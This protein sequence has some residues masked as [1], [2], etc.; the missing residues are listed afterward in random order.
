MVIEQLGPG[1]YKYTIDKE[2][3]ISVYN[4]VKTYLDPFFNLG[5]IVTHSE[6]SYNNYVNTDIRNAYVVSAR[7]SSDCHP[8]DPRYQIDN[9]LDNETNEAINHFLI[10]YGVQDVKPLH[11]WIYMK[12]DKNG[13]F[14][15]HK[16]D[17]ATLPRTVSVISYLNDNFEGGEIEFPYFNVIFKPKAG[18]ILVFSSAFPYVHNIKK[19]ESGERYIAVKWYGYRNR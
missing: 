3:V 6:S 19:I 4:Q 12:Y 7:D 2:N 17:G 11:D 14:Q 1:I 5:Q 9:L 10:N 8:E 16:D 15:N 13:F 18:D